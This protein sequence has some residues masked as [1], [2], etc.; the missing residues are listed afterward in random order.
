VSPE[1][2][3]QGPAARRGDLVVIHHHHGDRPLRGEPH[4]YDTFTVGVVTSVTRQGQVRLVKEAG[5]VDQPGWRGQPDRGTPPRSAGLKQIFVAS[6]R[7]ID[8]DGA[9]ATATC[10]TWPH[11]AGV[12]PYASLDD[13]RAALRPHLR[14]QPGWEQ[15]HD[16][17]EKHAA[18]RQAAWAAYLADSTTAQSYE[19]YEAELTAVNQAYLAELLDQ[20]P[21]PLPPRMAETL[22]HLNG[23]RAIEL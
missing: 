16:A 3:D 4:E 19:N 17:A 13:A 15:L 11:T 5:H 7:T 14:T 10:H 2:P 18:A 8:T 1:Q 12:R 21:G 23:D 22:G 6:S 9:L 20:P